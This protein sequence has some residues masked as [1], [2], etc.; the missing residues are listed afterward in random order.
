MKII[1]SGAGEVGKYLAQMLTKENHDTIVVDT[2]KD[3]LK[4][5][6][7][8]YDLMTITGSCSSF[9]TLEDA[10][11]STADLFIAVTHS[12]EINLLSAMLAKRLGAKKTIARID[13]IE[14]IDPVRKLH[15]INMG[16]D[17]MIYPEKIAAKEVV[18]LIRETGTNQVFEFSDGRLN[19]FVVFLSE[20]A[21]IINKTLKEA[22][23]I[24]NSFDYRAVAI[25][26]SGKTIIPSGDDVLK[27]GDHVYVITSPEGIDSLMKYAGKQK[28]KFDN[29]MI[30][31]GSRIGQKVA[32]ELSKNCKI[33]LIEKNENKALELAD[34][35]DRCLVIHGDGRNMDLL[36]E[37]GI[38]DM[39]AFVAVTG[40][41][42]TNILSCMLAKKL[43]I[44][45]TIAEIENFD[46]F[47]F[48]QKMGID[49]IVNKKLSAASRIYSF[50]MH[51]EVSS[52]KCLTSTDAELLEFVVKEK[53]RITKDILR[54]LNFPED[55]IVGG[56]VRGKKSFI[57]TG[58]THIVK[59]DKVV[60]FT[61][62]G[63][64]KKVEKFF[65]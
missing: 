6:E 42:E 43:G 18:A 13:N 1:I 62:P 50:T 36:E 63:S 46:Y 40:D 51:A 27:A 4:I 47:D 29:V 61:L 22:T 25:T 2:N 48:A 60:V 59:G 19:L 52:M 20:D 28:D 57:A 33:K 44:K 8:Q 64:I 56:V 7:Q 58:N 31:G 3:N 23:Q 21:P 49:S 15:F 34:R 17:R 5:V 10:K 53:A 39:D 24:S 35:L 38:K 45:K 37:E 9:K 11:V 55:A 14:Y 30:L 65:A 41:S 16:V 26:R 12:E 54:N 32:N